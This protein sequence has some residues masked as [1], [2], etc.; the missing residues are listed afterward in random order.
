MSFV[1][2]AG[3]KK[4]IMNNYYKIGEEK[5]YIEQIHAANKLIDGA[6]MGEKKSLLLSRTQSGKTG[7][8]I[9]FILKMRSFN[10]DIL[11]LYLCNKPDKTIKSQNTDRLKNAFNNQCDGDDLVI[12]IDMIEFVGDL[13]GK[14]LSL[15]YTDYTT[16]Q[17]AQNIKKHIRQLIKAGGTVNL[18]IDEAHYAL[19]GEGAIEE[20]L[21]QLGVDFRDLHTEWNN[22]NIYVTTV[23]A[24]PMQ[25]IVDMIN[26]DRE[27]PKSNIIILPPGDGYRGVDEILNNPL[28]TDISNQSYYTMSS[29]KSESEEDVTNIS[30]SP[31]LETELIKISIENEFGYIL[32]RENDLKKM[33]V[34][35][36]AYEKI[37]A[38][39][40]RVGSTGSKK[41]PDMDPQAA[42]KLLG[43]KPNDIVV[44][45]L[46]LCYSAGDT[47]N[48]KYV[49]AHFEKAGSSN[50][51]TYLQRMRLTGYNKNTKCRIYASAAYLKRIAYFYE[52]IENAANK[53]WAESV[54]ALS[55][56]Y[57]NSGIGTE[58]EMIFKFEWSK[59]KRVCRTVSN[60]SVNDVAGQLC[61][62][63]R[64]YGGVGGLHHGNSCIKIDKANENFKIPF[65]NLMQKIKD[66]DF[67]DCTWDE[68]CKGKIY[69]HVEK[70]AERQ[71]GRKDANINKKGMLAKV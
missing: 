3:R 1:W 50:D 35:Q 6:L 11:T 56:T 45:L 55:S 62:N 32:H 2:K 29:V 20:L 46:D 47:L 67:E 23:T 17:H 22:Q 68:F 26:E 53:H 4:I 10:P 65:E 63:P 39:V 27:N 42:K 14:I 9:D 51:E 13:R 19:K 59:D 28:F 5:I 48:D 24:S 33:E 31:F 71:F 64:L 54:V 25:E 61:R 38:R 7:C 18:V 66:G 41:N 52:Q 36:E 16:S 44:L 58:Q 30:I 70:S 49:I 60:N 8:V 34:L 57:N 21:T 43:I 15:T 40:H 37:G 12:D 69:V